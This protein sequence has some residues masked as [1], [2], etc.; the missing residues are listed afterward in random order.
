MFTPPVM[1]TVPWGTP[2]PNQNIHNVRGPCAGVG[3]NDVFWWTVPATGDRQGSCVARPSISRLP[4]TACRMNSP[5]SPASRTSI[6]PT[7]SRVVEV[8][9]DGGQIDQVNALI[10]RE[11][12][13]VR[14]PVHE[15]LDLGDGFDEIEQP[16]RVEQVAVVVS[17]RMMKEQ[18]HRLVVAGL[19]VA[20]QPGPLGLAQQ[21]R[22][23]RSS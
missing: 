10:V 21:P 1:G 5:P 20:L 14:V 3:R 13:F 11:C 17:K 9:T 7:G 23:S 19:K 6:Q 2:V 4:P 12:V 16:W 18:D 8:V 15:G 22:S